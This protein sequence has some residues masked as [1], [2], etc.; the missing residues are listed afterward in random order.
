MQNFSI[1]NILTLTSDP[2]EVARVEIFLDK[3]NKKIK[4]DDLHFNKLLVATT[5]AVNNSIIHGNQRVQEK[6]VTVICEVNQHV[7]IIYVEDEGS[8]VDPEKLPN[9]LCE[10][11]ILRENGRG[12]F[13]MRSLMDEVEFRRTS[14][15]AS[16]IMKMYLNN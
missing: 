1:K 10:E 15:G 3:I 8:G 13:L 4:L 9:P 12:V 5:E 6:K 16:V 2:K 11:N 14:K 7:L